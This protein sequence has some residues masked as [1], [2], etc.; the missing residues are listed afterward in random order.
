VNNSRV[1]TAVLALIVSV[2]ALSARAQNGDLRQRFDLQPVP[3]VPYPENNRFNP[4]RV[5]L[6]R[7]LFFDPILSGEKDTACGTC[8][9]PTFGMADGRQLAAGTSGKGLGPERVLGF[10]AI[11]GDTVIS[12]P[13]HTMTLFNVAYNGDESGLPSPKG[14]MLWD[15]KD[16]G[17]EAQ[18]LRP[19]IVRVELRGDAYPR[20]MAVDSVLARLESIPEYM[21]LFNRA[22]P[23]EADSVERQLP[24]L[25]CVHDPT[26]LQS[27][28][29]RSTLGRALAAFERE[30]NTVNTAYDRYVAGDDGALGPAELRGLELFHGK[31]NCAS[32]HSGPLFTDSSFR[33]QGVEQVGPGR[34]SATTNT[35]TPRPTGRDEGRFL[36]TGNREDIGAFRVVGLRQIAQTAPYMHD[37]ALE[38]LV[39]VIEFYDRGG[40]DDA[41]I[42]PENLDPD[43]FSLGLT[44]GEKQDL[45]S[46]MHA[47]TDSTIRV[48]VPARVPSGLPPV[49]LELVDEVDMVFGGMA[50][51]AKPAAVELFNYPNP[52]NAE[53]VI[54]MSLPQAFA[55]K[56]QVYNALGQAVR[57]LMKGQRSPGIYEMT[58]DGRDSAGRE[59]ASGLYLVSAQIG[60]QRHLSR[61]LLVR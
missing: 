44:A 34:A 57:T 38:T 15:G 3:P 59:A 14:F 54:S 20:E 50:L 39:D 21:G 22:F 48:G 28:I 24:R 4:D 41:S 37:G 16:R 40:G 9:L 46:F 51:A 8:H 43:L 53:T 23:A 30:Q 31:A 6:G 11:T 27:V 60:P 32:C 52:F 19:L 1:V 33:V 7:L 2:G 42:D 25:G 45:L 5:E 58:W 47:L 17:L 12:E 35:G 18:A 49:G 29:T 10:S 55:V 13:R 26:P 36:N 56:V 61:M